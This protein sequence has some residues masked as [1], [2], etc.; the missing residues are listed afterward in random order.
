MVLLV[1]GLVPAEDV[2]GLP[3]HQAQFG[4]VDRDLLETEK[5]APQLLLAFQ[6]RE[7][8][9]DPGQRNPRLDAMLES[10]Q[11]DLQV[12]C[13][14]QLRVIDLDLP[15]LD[16]LARLGSRRPHRAFRTTLGG[17]HSRRLYTR[18]AVPPAERAAGLC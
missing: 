16:D 5:R 15:E 10:Q 18:R 4:P 12:D 2:G 17:I 14:G 7:V 3:E 6:P 13:F 11:L 9:V 8:N 1:Q